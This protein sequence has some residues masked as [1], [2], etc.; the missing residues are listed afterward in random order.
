MY[1]SWHYP[2]CSVQTCFKG[3]FSYTFCS[4]TVTVSLGLPSLFL[5]FLKLVCLGWKRLST[6]CGTNLDPTSLSNV[7]FIKLLKTILLYPTLSFLPFIVSTIMFYSLPKLLTYWLFNLLYLYW[8]RLLPCWE[9]LIK[10][11]FFYLVKIG[12]SINF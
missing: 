4:G 5:V 7:F 12:G 8:S 11:A 9:F 1:S 2:S 3:R 10:G 6:F